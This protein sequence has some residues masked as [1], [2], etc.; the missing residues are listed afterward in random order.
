[1]GI[2]YIPDPAR[3]DR[4]EALKAAARVAWAAFETPPG[5]HQEDC[6]KRFDCECP[7]LRGEA[8]E[9]WDRAR[10]DQ[11]SDRVMILAERFNRYLA[12][13]TTGLDM[14]AALRELVTG[15]E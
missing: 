7:P 10:W 14:D 9:A 13:G 5:H 8:W 4:R 1:M 3:Q 12:D 11:K 6:N 15:H 2:E